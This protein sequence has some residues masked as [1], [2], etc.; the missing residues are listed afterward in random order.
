MVQLRP[1]P[2]HSSSRHI[3]R[4]IIVTAIEDYLEATAPTDDQPDGHATTFTPSEAANWVLRRLDEAECTI[5]PAPP[6]Q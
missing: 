1:V 2:R 6:K 5:T 4:A 3:V